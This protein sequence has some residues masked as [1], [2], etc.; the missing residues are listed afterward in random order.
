MPLAACMDR[1]QPATRRFIKGYNGFLSEGNPATGFQRA[2]TAPMKR[3][4]ETV[5]Q[6]VLKR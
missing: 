2:F 3:R 1:I 6:W 5:V 4:D